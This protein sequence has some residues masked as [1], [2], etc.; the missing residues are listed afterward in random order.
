MKGLYQNS[1]RNQTVE[2]LSSE[3]SKDVFY[4]VLNGNDSNS[5]KE[6]VCTIERFKNLYIKQK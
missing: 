2:V 1:T 5:I 3:G 6:F 4:R